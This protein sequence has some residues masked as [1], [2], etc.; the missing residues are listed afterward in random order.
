MWLREGVEHEVQIMGYSTTPWSPRN[1]M[2]EPQVV[3][4][5]SLLGIS[6]KPDPASNVPQTY[7]GAKFQIQVGWGPKF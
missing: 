5:L 3:E 7:G 6:G 1:I 2:S 4:L